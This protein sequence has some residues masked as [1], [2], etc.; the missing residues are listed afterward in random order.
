MGKFHQYLQNEK[1]LREVKQNSML[2]QTSF[3]QAERPPT[4]FKMCRQE[5]GFLLSNRNLQT[6]L[7]RAVGSS[8]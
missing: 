5:A 8:C 2:F 3:K 7:Y 6:Y 4:V 1:K